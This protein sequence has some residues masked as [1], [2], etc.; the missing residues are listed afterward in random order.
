[1]TATSSP[2]AAGAAPC[3]EA[4]PFRFAN[5]IT[6]PFWVTV[7]SLLLL[8]IVAAWTIGRA[9]QDAP[10]PSVVLRYQQGLTVEMAQ[11]VRRGL[12]EGIADL[13]QMAATTAADAG[14]EALEKAGRIVLDVHD[15]YDV[16][17]VVE[18]DG[19]VVAKVGE[20]RPEPLPSPTP[21]SESG[22][23]PIPSGAV[24]E[25]PL[26]QQFSPIVGGRT[27][28]A[29]Y[30]PA[31]LKF[32][33]NAIAPGQAYLVNDEG[34]V[35]SAS[36][37]FRPFAGLEADLRT[38]A[39]LAAG[40]SSGSKVTSSGKARGDVITW[41]PVSGEGAGGQLGLS[42]VTRQA[43]GSFATPSTDARREGLVVAVLVA[44]ITVALASWIWLVVLAPIRRLRLEAERVA[45]GDLSAPVAILRYDEIGL[46]SRALDRLRVLLVSAR[47]SSG[48]KAGPFTGVVRGPS[49]ARRIVAALGIVLGLAVF[50][51]GLVFLTEVGSQAIDPVPTA[52]EP[53]SPTPVPT[54]AT[55]TSLAVQIEPVSCVAQD[56]AV[57]YLAEV[58]HL[59]TRPLLVRLQIVVVGADGATVAEQRSEEVR[60]EAD[61]PATVTVTIPVA[62]GA[63]AEGATCTVRSI[64]SVPA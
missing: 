25:P 31:F 55:P 14:T 43:V 12:N 20:G 27:V 15:R 3:G 40:G 44:G 36:I 52:S 2:A 57:V 11:N 35:V 13:E 5:S 64:E 17:F 50:V 18:A 54:T 33:L 1:M 48:Q 38:A 22:I 16:V 6:L 58:R 59:G 29:H 42:V 60:I 8:A 30:D 39:E 26:I 24:G 47:A 46:A 10:L 63:S 4:R 41:A 45:H 32:A 37:G 9:G 28:I 61:R 56:E 21:P 51:A 53:S 62:P 34:K 23:A 19:S 49:K 7:A